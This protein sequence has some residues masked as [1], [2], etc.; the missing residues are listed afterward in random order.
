MCIILLAVVSLGTGDGQLQAVRNRPGVS[1]AHR[2][3]EIEGGDSSAPPQVP[4]GHSHVPGVARE[5]RGHDC[6]LEETQEE[7]G[8]EHPSARTRSCTSQYFHRYNSVDCIGVINK[9]QKLPFAVLPQ[10]QFCRLYWCDQQEAEARFAVLPQKQFCRLY[11]WH[12]QEMEAAL[13]NTSTDTILEIV[14]V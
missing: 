9:N 1:Y 2:T 13:H 3:G 7:L 6:C 8:Q 4:H 5:R 10:T 12:K 11:W 14:L